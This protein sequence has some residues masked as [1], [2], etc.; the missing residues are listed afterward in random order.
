MRHFEFVNFDDPEYV[1][2]NIHVRAGLTGSSVAWAFTSTEAANWF[3]LT[4]LSH[5]SVYQLFGL[6]SGWHHL[7]NVL[8]H[9]LA[10]LLLFAAFQH[11]TGALWRSALVAFL[12]ALHPLHVESVA[13]VAERKDVLC[14]LFW[15]LTIW[16]YARYVRRPSAAGYLFVVAAFAGGLMSKSM[17][18]TLP[19]VLLLLDLWP[20]GRPRRIGLVWEKL[21]LVAMASAVSLVTYISQQQGNAIRSLSS[22]PFGLR[23]A[24]ALLTYVRYIVRM[25]WPAKLAVYYPY[26]HELPPWQVAAAVVVLAGITALAVRWFRDYPYLAVGWFWYLGTLAPVIGLVQVGGQSSADRYTYLPMVGLTIMLSWGA[27]DLVQKYPRA[28][29]AATAAAVAACGACVALTWIQLGYWTNSEALFQHAVDVT[30]DNY[31]A[32][33]NLADDYLVHLRNEEARGHVVEA[34]R[35]NPNYPEAHIN[36]ATILRRSG[37][38]DESEKEYRTALTLQENN[39]DGHSGYGALLLRQGRV[40]EALRELRRVVELRPEYAEGHHDLGRLL[41]SVGRV[42]DAMAQFSEAIRLRPDYA[43]AHHSLGFAL[44]GRGRLNEAVVE[45]AAEAELLP[46]DANVH[47]N[48]AMLLVSLGRLDDAIAQFSAAL[49]IKPDF[50]AARQGL[51]AAQAQKKR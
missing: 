7:A 16:C 1:S 26:P 29:M 34:L 36:L 20:L 12:F 44:A 45:F 2:G 18:V 50:D 31:I 13:W 17:M 39:V 51:A 49:R 41:A 27:A 46:Q 40:N 28:R 9:T 11:M 30:T 25:F 8:F 4:W 33:N 38:L 5:M 47:N 35:L 6:D 23:V 32:H 3:P 24:N 21:P 42:D 14:A 22:L 48:L 15:F 19:L 37:Q 43:E 10:S